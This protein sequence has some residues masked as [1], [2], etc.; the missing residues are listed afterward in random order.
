[1]AGH[2]GENH[3]FPEV[4]FPG[5]QLGPGLWEEMRISELQLF[6]GTG[7]TGRGPGWLPWLDVLWPVTSPLRGSCLQLLPSAVVKVLE[8]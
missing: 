5:S 2:G 6:H 4:P 8:I 1:M 7:R 3:A